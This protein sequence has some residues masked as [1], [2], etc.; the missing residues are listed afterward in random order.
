MTIK[1]KQSILTALLDTKDSK[2]H[3]EKTYLES[4]GDRPVN[5]VVWENVGNVS[6]EAVSRRKHFGA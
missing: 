4:Q 1:I 6:P 2:T 3:W 5:E